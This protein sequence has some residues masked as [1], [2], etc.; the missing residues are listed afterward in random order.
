M[1]LVTPPTTLYLMCHVTL[2]TSHFNHYKVY[3]WIILDTPTWLI[4]WPLVE[5]NSVLVEG[6]KGTV[7]PS[8]YKV[9][10]L[11][12]PMMSHPFTALTPPT[13]RCPL[14]IWLGI[15]PLQYALSL[16]QELKTKP[17]KQQMVFW[18][19]SLNINKELIIR[20]NERIIRVRRLFKDNGF[21]DFSKTL[22][23]VKDDVF[24]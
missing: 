23:H 7:P 14:P 22:I 10:P 9:S 11:F 21:K 24:I 5:P 6:A 15:G 3:L 19:G 4:W 2:P 1:R 17:S 13:N 20:I 16:G 18:R 12:P 8:D